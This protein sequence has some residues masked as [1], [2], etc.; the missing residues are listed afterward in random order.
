MQ[1]PLSAALA[2]FLLVPWLCASQTIYVAPSG[3]DSV[4]CASVTK[5]TPRRSWNGGIACLQPGGTLAVADGTYDELVLSQTSSSRECSSGDAAMQSP[6]SPLPN[7]LDPEHPTR[8]VGSGGGVIL[9]PAG[10]RLPGGGSAITLFDYARHVA[11]ENIRVVKNS[12]SGSTGG[13]YI[14]NAQHITLT[15]NE[16]DDGQ[17]KG[18]SSSRDLRIVGNYVHHTGQGQCPA[19]VKPTPADCPHAMYICGTDH[20]ITDNLIEYAS[21]YGIQVSCE[22]GGI[23]RIKIERNIVRYS[24]VVGIRCA[25]QD[26]TVASNLLYG[27]GQGMTLAGSGL[28]A[29]NTIDGYMPASY[30]SDPWGI[31]YGGNYQVVNNIV[32]NQKSAYYAIANDQFAPPDTSTVHH[33]LC[34]APGNPACTLQGSAAQVYT[35][36][37]Q[38][39]YTLRLARDNPALGAGVPVAGVTTD[40]RGRPYHGAHPSVGAYALELPKPQPEPPQ[41]GAL[42]LV[43]EGNV[44]AI[45]G[46]VTMVCTPQEGRR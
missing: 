11:I 12:A 23:A 22:Q 25:G 38:G 20:T 29:H 35:N 41:P 24:A 45:P 39:A 7:G 3:N 9:S 43:C 26:C 1:R 42:V 32:T 15:R 19:G 46:R 13:I 6:C 37:S 14:G 17:I 2:L 36:V 16:L 34:E 40:L 10:R 28:V 27:N 8:I 44:E 33:N 31:Y 4:A 18:G 5:T 30:N 21:Y